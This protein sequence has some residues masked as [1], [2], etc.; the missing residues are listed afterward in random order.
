MHNVKSVQ[1]GLYCIRISF[2]LSFFLVFFLFLSL[3]SLTDNNDSS[4]GTGEGIIIFLVFHFHPLTNIHFIY[5]HFYLFFLLDLFDRSDSWWGLFS[6]DICIFIDAI[7]SELLTLTFQSD[8]VRIWVHIKLSPFYYKANDLKNWDLH[9]Y[10]PLSIYHTYS[11]L[12]LAT[13]CPL[14]VSQNI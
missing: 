13:T 9:S 2:F 4:D 12:Y 8:I 7:N 3:F 5:W 1:F 14:T 11:A 10:P 6:L